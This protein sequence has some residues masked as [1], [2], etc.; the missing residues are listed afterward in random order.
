MSVLKIHARKSWLRGFPA[1]DQA[2][3]MLTTE[4]GRGSPEIRPSRR[5]R[6][7][8]M[9]R[10]KPVQPDISVRL[11][12]PEL[13]GKRHSC[14]AFLTLVSRI[15]RLGRI[16]ATTA[17]GNRRIQREVAVNAPGYDRPF[18]KL[19]YAISNHIHTSLKRSVS[20]VR[21]VYFA[22]KSIRSPKRRL[23]VAAVQ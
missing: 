20:T 16:V 7:R 23:S 22:C 21:L 11:C 1:G 18:R 6:R 8:V 12:M 14:S 2:L 4:C 3:R 13:A 5:C 17:P 10:M 9:G 15:P 19:D